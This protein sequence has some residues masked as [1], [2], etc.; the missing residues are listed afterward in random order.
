MV[1][2]AASGP[3]NK[4]RSK[5][6]PALNSRLTRYFSI[7]VGACA[8]GSQESF[9]DIVNINVG[10]GTGGFNINGLNGGVASNTYRRVNNFPIFGA[11]NILYIYN[12]Y[13]GTT[14]LGGFSFNTIPRF[15]LAVTSTTGSAKIKNFA[16]STS[17]SSSSL[18]NDVYT[19]TAFKSGGTSASIF[20]T[21]NYVGFRFGTTG[22]YNYG[23]LQTTWDGTNFQINS[24][25]YESTVN[26]AILAGAAAPVPEPGTLGLGSLALL[27]GGGAAVRRYR[28]QR[29]QQTTTPAAE[30][31]TEGPESATVS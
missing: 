28:K 26:T 25:A 1:T 5:A 10:S 19:N 2:S 8:L 4:S 7:S 24:G 14:G 18:F 13:R 29:Q 11:T 23:W 31:G 6:P 16:S 30:P 12:N 20:T 9:A 17:I 22:S 27:A 3:K 15:Q 21:S